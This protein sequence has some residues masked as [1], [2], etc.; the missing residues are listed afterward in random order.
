[1]SDKAFQ[2]QVSA[3][4]PMMCDGSDD[5][6]KCK[7]YITK[8]LM[9]SNFVGEVKSAMMQDHAEESK[10]F[11]NKCE[12]IQR[13]VPSLLSVLQWVQDPMALF[14]KAVTRA[15]QSTGVNLGDL[16]SSAEGDLDQKAAAED[17]EMGL[18]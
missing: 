11:V 5:P 3:T 7:Q 4:V 8:A 14:N 13:R 18:P 12:A 9:C 1:M 17:A 6:E 10:D 15:E 16:Q 2:E